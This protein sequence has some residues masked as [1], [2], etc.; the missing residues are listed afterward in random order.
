M[1]STAFFMLPAMMT[2]A[3][4]GSVMYAGASDDDILVSDGIQAADA[5]AA[6]K[7]KISMSASAEETIFRDAFLMR[8]ELGFTYK[9]Y[10]G[11]SEGD[12]LH[13]TISYQDY[14]TAPVHIVTSP[15]QLSD[16]L[17]DA[18]SLS[19]P[20]LNVVILDY[21]KQKD[22]YDVSAVMED[23]IRSHPLTRS[24]LTQQAWNGWEH[25]YSDD[26][27]LQFTF[28]YTEPTEKS[29]FD[30][31]QETEQAAYSLAAGLFM[32]TM[33]DEEK[34]LLAHD[35]VLERCAY[36]KERTD[37]VFHTAYG[38]LCLGEAVC[39][40]YAEAFALLMEMGGVPCLVVTGDAENG[41]QT[42]HHAWNLVYVNDKWYHVDLTWDDGFITKKHTYFL[43]DDSFF[44]KE[45][46]WDRDAYPSAAED[47]ETY[48]LILDV[49][50]TKMERNNICALDYLPQCSEQ[51][52]ILYLQEEAEMLRKAMLPCAALDDAMDAMESEIPQQTGYATS[53]VPRNVN[54]A[55]DM[56]PMLVVWAAVLVIALVTV[57]AKKHA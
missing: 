1:K 57:F 10:S 13:L 37:A 39:E 46:T 7:T 20:S 54:H 47:S 25:S 44:E 22:S 42:E 23:M 26:C 30:M 33:T 49:L 48:T 11:Y 15:E 28:T 55:D 14:G 53:Y 29:V 24:F 40:G 43:R 8:P 17:T 27:Y 16:L 45:H 18:V 3:L 19:Q 52:K 56:K 36:A 9:G 50:R 35:A 4:F 2:A 12:T 41:G 31:K 21:G 34:V 5:L 51:A 6:G 38:A 32:D